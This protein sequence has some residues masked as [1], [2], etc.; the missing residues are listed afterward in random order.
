MQSFIK[1]DGK[2]RIDW[3]AT[4]HPIGDQILDHVL[5]GDRKRNIGG[6]L[7]GQGIV[8][9][10]EFSES[11][12][13]TRIKRSIAQVMERPL[14]VRKAAHEFRPTTFGAEIDGVQIEVKAFLYQGRYVIERAYPVGGEGVIMNMKNGDKIE[15]KKSRAKVW[16][17][18]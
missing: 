10:R 1:R 4:T 8:G 16:I 7:H 3:P 5:Y 13:A 15:V 12:D 18:A 14:W 2:P 6:H 11:W 9:K 17:G